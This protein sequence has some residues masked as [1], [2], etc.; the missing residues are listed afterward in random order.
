VKPDLVCFKQDLC[1]VVDPTICSD[2]V[3]KSKAN[4]GKIRKYDKPEVINWCRLEYEKT[5]FRLG[6]KLAVQVS[7]VV[8]DWR[9]AWLDSSWMLLKR[10]GIPKGFLE[11]LSIKLLRYGKKALTHASKSTIV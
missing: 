6:P 7:G 5:G 9:G 2:R 10:H 4:E 1:L 11:L 8:V 3:D